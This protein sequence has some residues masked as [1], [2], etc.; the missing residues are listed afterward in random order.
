MPV[1]FLWMIYAGPSDQPGWNNF[2]D[3]MDWWNAQREQEF[4]Q[5][6]AR[7]KPHGYP[8]SCGKRTITGSDPARGGGMDFSHNGQ[9]YWNY[10]RL[11]LYSVWTYAEGVSPVQESTSYRSL[12]GDA[13]G[14]MVA[15]AAPL[16]PRNMSGAVTNLTSDGRVREVK[17][18]DPSDIACPDCAVGDPSR[19]ASPPRIGNPINPVNSSKEQLE[20]D[21]VAEGGLL[22]V[23]RFYSSAKLKWANGTPFL[24]DFTPL[25]PGGQSPKHDT[26]YYRSND[27]LSWIPIRYQVIP[28]IPD[29]VEIRDAKGVR[30]VLPVTPQGRY[31]TPDATAS[32]ER[33]VLANGDIEWHYR[34]GNNS[35]QVYD[36]FG[37]LLKVVRP[38][39]R[40]A[41]FS[42]PAAGVSLV[43]SAQSGRALTFGVQ[44]DGLLSHVRL[45]DGN[46]ISYVGAE[47][48]YTSIL[49]ADGTSKRYLYDEPALAP[50]NNAWGGLLTGLIGELGVRSGTYTYNSSGQ[51]ISTSRAN[52]AS[53]YKVD[54]YGTYTRVLDPQENQT[55]LYWYSAPH[56]VKRLQT[57]SQP[58]GSG[59]AAASS[60]FAFDTSGS[61]S[62]ACDTR[63]SCTC[64]SVDPSRALESTRVEGVSSGAACSSVFALNAVLPAG[65]RKTNTLW[66]PDWRLETRVAEPGRITTSIYNGQPDPFNGNAVASCAPTSAL[67]PDGKPIAV[68]CKRVEQATTDA[69]GAAGFSAVLQSGVP[70]R[71]TTWTYNQWGQVLTENGPRTDVN[72]TTTYTYFSDTSFT[73][74]GAAATGHFMGDLA[75]VTNAAGRVTQYTQYNKHGQVLES[76]DPNGVVTSNTYDLRQRLLSTT[77]AGRTTQYTYDPVG[78]LKRVTL[79]DQS[80]IGYDYDD[81]QRQVAVYD[82]KG[83]RV[84]YTLDNAGNRIAEQTKD[85][86]GALKRQLAR[87]IDA[88]GRVQQTTGRE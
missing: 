25:R 69:N 20:I 5:C 43:T 58:A 21:Y 47:A 87:S 46:R 10:T 67:L 39:G 81:A 17:C 1:D 4:A 22:S 53:Q 72:D 31:M 12:D 30:V 49:Y 3:L 6:M 18:L 73:G 38:S 36:R 19:Y 83:N 65:S 26:H 24:F 41:L 56:G 75:T 85:P 54:N 33:F 88:L 27:G 63:G 82:H 78:Q 34:T 61:L 7:P 11:T 40:T 86:S 29:V 84:D 74:E 80:W 23:E 79:P 55:L 76:I 28:S 51:A 35:L 44:P 9:P 13:S 59:S 66:H 8:W 68:L 77:T 48:R 14:L 60:T 62:R 52:G 70:A 15:T 64:F 37:T 2:G 32:A 16:C 45:P 71:T 42:Y 57:V 50:G